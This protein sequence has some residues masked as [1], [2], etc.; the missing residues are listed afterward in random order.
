MCTSSV[1][2]GLLTTLPKP[3]VPSR[4]SG[5]LHTA[6]HSPGTS[7]RLSL[8]FG[9]KLILACATQSEFIFLLTEYGWLSLLLPSLMH[10]GSCASCTGSSR[11][12]SSFNCGARLPPR[13]R[14]WASRVRRRSRCL[15]AR[16][17]A[18]RGPTWRARHA[19]R[20]SANGIQRRRSRIDIYAPGGIQCFDVREAL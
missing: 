16:G 20:A 2:R 8:F 11:A 14:M 3:D 1:R 19:S 5:E 6:I 13:T 9:S 12:A 15:P 7:P 18:G 4:V 17:C 10:P